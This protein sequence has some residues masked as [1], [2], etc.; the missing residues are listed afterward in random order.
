M[1]RSVFDRMENIVGKGEN[2][3]NQCFEKAS[4]PD[5]SKGVVVWKWVNWVR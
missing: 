2:A 5:M 3:G 1:I 4:V